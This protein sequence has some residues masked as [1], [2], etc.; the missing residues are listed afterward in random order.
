MTPQNPAHKHTR[1]IAQWDRQD[2]LWSA[3]KALPFWIVGATLLAVIATKFV[4]H[5]A[6]VGVNYQSCLGG[7]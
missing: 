3:I 5:M 4:N 7:C 2:M 6:Y 1:Q